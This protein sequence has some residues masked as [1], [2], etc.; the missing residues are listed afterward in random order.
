MVAKRSS[1]GHL[2]RI[3]RFGQLGGFTSAAAVSALLLVAPAGSGVAPHAVFL[4]APYKTATWIPY[5]SVYTGGC[6]SA[7]ILNR[8]AWSGATGIGSFAFTAQSKGCHQTIGNIHPSSQGSAGGQFDLALPVHFSKSGGHLVTV[9]WTLSLQTNQ[10]IS[11]A[12]TCVP[13]KASQNIYCSAASS[14]NDYGY[15]YLRDLT[16]GS[17]VPSSNYWGGISNSSYMQS[18]VYCY[19]GT[20]GYGYALGR[21]WNGG[22]LN[23]NTTFQWVMNASGTSSINATHQYVLEIYFSAGGA[24]GEYNYGSGYATASQNMATNGHGWKLNFIK[25]V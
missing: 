4:K 22:N 2:L 7:K 15:G 13:P 8:P 3:R 25:I 18:T 11:A 20:C 9:N 19:Q 23:G 1:A 14:I 12:G 6:G 16:N 21:S 5:W 24:T 17:T 10:S